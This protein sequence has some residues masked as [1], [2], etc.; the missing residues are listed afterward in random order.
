MAIALVALGSNL[1][2][3]RQNLETGL[4]EL[5]AQSGIRLVA[6]STFHSTRPVGG[7]PG[8]DGFLNAAAR[9]ETSLSPHQLHSALKA[10]ET[11]AGRVRGE[12]WAPRTLDLDLL[13]YDRQII[14]T[15]E[16]TVPHPRMAFRRFVLEPAAEIAPGMRH[17]TIGWTVEELYRHV[18]MRTPYVAAIA[19]PIAADKTALARMA[20]A[21]LAGQMI[22]DPE[23]TDVEF[24]NFVTNRLSYEKAVE[25][26]ELRARPIRMTA[27]AS[28]AFMTISDYW[29]PDSGLHS[30]PSEKRGEYVSRFAELARSIA[31]PKL[32]AILESSAS[33]FSRV[34]WREAGRPSNRANLESLIGTTLQPL[35]PDEKSLWGG[36]MLFLDCDEPEAALK[37]L[38]AAIQS[39]R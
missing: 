29:F 13:L 16:L 2:D 19:G 30:M 28:T 24:N 20:T 7:P 21:A 23:P 27:W 39:M 37:E 6:K 31:Q 22:C 38:V 12:R 33:R 25:L 32:V 4:V 8:Q 35:A 9:L 11:V 15:P 3:R 36:P 18:Q 26:L 17:P 5:A 34:W 10:T 1:G 14:E